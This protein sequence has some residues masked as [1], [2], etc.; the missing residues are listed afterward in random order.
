[1]HKNASIVNILVKYTKLGLD[2]P[3]LRIE[4]KRLYDAC[5]IGL[6]KM[7][8]SLQHLSR[9]EPGK[10]PYTPL[11]MAFEKLTHLT[12]KLLPRAG[13]E[14]AALLENIADALGELDAI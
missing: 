7:C 12:A 5:A 10:S 1:M 13:V 6:L 9:M 3:A 11:S 8:S 2:T 4:D 14:D